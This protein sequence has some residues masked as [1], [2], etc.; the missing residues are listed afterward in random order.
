VGRR[1]AQSGQQRLGHADPA[2]DRN[3]LDHGAQPQ[4]GYA[5]LTAVSAVSAGDVWTVGATTD[6]NSPLVFQPLAEHWDGTSWNFVP[7]PSFSPG[8]TLSAV[9]AR[10]ANDAWAVGSYVANGVTQNLTEHWNGTSWSQVP[11]PDP[12]GS[13]QPSV[14]SGVAATTSGDVW[15]VGTYGTNPQTTPFMLHWNGSSWTS[16]FV[17][18]PGQ[19]AGDSVTAA[20]AAAPG[21]AWIAGNSDDRSR[22]FA[23]PLPVVPDLIGQTSASASALL[24]TYGLV[25]GTVNQTTTCGG[26][27]QGLVA[28][29]SPAN[30]QQEPFATAVDLTI[31]AAAAAVTVPNV[32]G[33]DQGS[34]Q[35]AITAAGLTVGPITLDN[36]CKDVAGTVLTQNPGGGS[37]AQ[38]GSAV[39]L[40]V[41][42][43][44][45]SDGKRCVF[46]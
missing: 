23:A 6:G 25:T 5:T 42:S 14:L 9:A 7:T 15:T 16:A 35:N 11:S 8:A 28:G 3:F 39:S 1:A 20:A 44:V 10:S 21:Q 30:D 40:T 17:D 4:P 22:T 46:N 34:A 26:V 29:Q 32:L 27:G 2:L 18:T 24:G 36:L 41:S 33:Q 13:T 19:G 45:T 31:C 38:P 43:G 12:G 37:Q